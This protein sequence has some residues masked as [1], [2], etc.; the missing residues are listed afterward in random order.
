MTPLQF[1]HIVELPES[2]APAISANQNLWFWIQEA[3]IY[4]SHLYEYEYEYLVQ[5][6][7]IIE[8]NSFGISRKYVYTSLGLLRRNRTE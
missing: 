8:Y 6:Q 1:L 5:E 2:F 3:I 7:G 4:Q